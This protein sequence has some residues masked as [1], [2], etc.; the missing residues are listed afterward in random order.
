MKK[1]RIKEYGEIEFNSYQKKHKI[2]KRYKIQYYR[3]WLLGW[4]E[5]DYVCLTEE[6]ARNRIAFRKLHDKVNSG[7]LT[8]YI[9]ID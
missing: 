5:L 2:E 9:N 3:G 6:E 4:G 1:Y 7:K 8:R